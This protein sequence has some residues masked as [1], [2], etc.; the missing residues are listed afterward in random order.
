[1]LRDTRLLLTGWMLTL[2]AQFANAE[3]DAVGLRVI[4]T[5][6]ASN[7]ER[8]ALL[9]QVREQQWQRLQAANRQSSA[10]WK[11]IQ[12]LDGWKRLRREKLDALKVSLGRWPDAPRQI[13]V[14]VSSTVEGDGFKVDNILFES[15]PGWW[16]SANLYRPDKPCPPAPGFVI[17]HAH[18]TPKEHGELQDMGMTWARAGCLVLVPDQVGHGERRQHPFATAADY[19]KPYRVG[20]ADYYFRYDNAI[21]LQLVGES[22]AGWM[23]WDL[24]RCAD[25]LAQHKL[26]GPQHLFLLGS[27]AG[28]GDPA[29]VA[30][31]LDDRFEVVVPFNFGGPQPETRYPL[32]ADAENS[33]NYAGGG[34]WEST[35]NLRNSA[36][37]GFLPWVIVGGIAPRRLIYAH[38]FRWDEA[39]D[40]VWKRLQTLYR[41]YDQPA[42]LAFTHGSGMVTGQSADDTH[43]THIGRV[44]R[45]LIHTALRDW[46]YVEVKPEDEYRQRLPAEQLRCWTDDLRRELQPQ[47][48]AQ[49]VRGIAGRQFAE[50]NALQ[51]KLAPA[52]FRQELRRRWTQRLGA[53]VAPQLKATERRSVQVEGDITVE[54]WM[55]T[56]SDDLRVPACVAIPRKIDGPTVIAV[57]SRGKHVFWKERA[58]D[59]ANWLKAGRVV[60]VLD[61][62]GIGESRLSDSRG[63]R[64]G[65]TSSSA[66]ELMLGGTLL[67]EQLS[68][69]R[70]LLNWLRSR[71]EL[72]STAFELH[73]DS[74]VPPN[75]ADALFRQPRDNDDA[76]PAVSQPAAPLLVLLTGLFEDDVARIDTRGGFVSWEA[77]L[78]SY[79]VLTAHDSL[80]PDVCLTGEISTL[81]AAQLPHCKV[82]S[83]N[84]VDS[85]NRAVP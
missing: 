11:S 40:P 48:L 4:D 25:V 34:S 36:R 42:A 38:E 64:S 56:T 3:V 61:P 44:Q 50:V 74:L 23:A 82:A 24:M 43:C 49:Q 81:I 45:A 58:A 10:E 39:R 7:E 12:S 6:V 57:C 83:S 31:A 62:R 55:L 46:S 26:G 67:G 71:T 77:M 84:A 17:C 53:T 47:T 2:I 70:G 65:A 32:P 28:G 79:L 76:L 19:S 41:W 37:D 66:T 1:M 16:V 85:W 35:R 69:V 13:R 15:R 27:V 60:C 78:S 73:G 68:D 75:P 18:H 22:L 20:H 30:G 63:R 9:N 29:A 72:R 59:I 21:Q 52:E 51:A 80:V 8:Q 5:T 54:R 14:V 33:F